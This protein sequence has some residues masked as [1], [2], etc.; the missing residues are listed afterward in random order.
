MEKLTS[1]SGVERSVSASSA[2]VWGGRDSRARSRRP[3]VGASK[4]SESTIPFY[5]SVSLSLCL[6]F[7]MVVGKR[8]RN[9]WGRMEPLARVQPGQRVVA[10]GGLQ[11]LIFVLI[12]PATFVGIRA[13]VLFPWVMEVG[14]NQFQFPRP[15]TGSFFSLSRRGWKRFRACL[16]SLNTFRFRVYRRS[17]PLRWFVPRY[18]LCAVITRLYMKIV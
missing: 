13:P 14:R 10:S 16:R 8:A 3:G 5:P 1:P 9:S 2:W 17:N 15:A 6:F 4:R 7:G 18:I 11:V 12:A